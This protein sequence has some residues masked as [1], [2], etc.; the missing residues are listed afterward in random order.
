MM[1][2]K[3]ADYYHLAHNTIAIDTAIDPS[4]MRVVVVTKT[5]D[6]RMYA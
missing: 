4:D 1:V 5:P 2:H 6:S 3:C